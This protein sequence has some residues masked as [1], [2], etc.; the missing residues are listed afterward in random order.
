MN[1]QDTLSESKFDD[2]WHV[3]DVSFLHGFLFNEGLGSSSFLLKLDTSWTFQV[4]GGIEIT[5]CKQY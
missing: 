2:D 1:H 5:K 3:E 4:S